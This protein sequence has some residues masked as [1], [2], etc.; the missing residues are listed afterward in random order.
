MN[1]TNSVNSINDYQVP[2][3]CFFGHPI[4]QK[5]PVWEMV[6]GAQKKVV[7]C[8]NTSQRRS[9]QKKNDYLYHILIVYW[10]LFST[11]H[12]AGSTRCFNHTRRHEREKDDICHWMEG[13]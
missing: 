7:S 2:T 12:M 6:W 10:M 1:L 3:C 13:G 8:D 11:S 4:T 9:S 5:V